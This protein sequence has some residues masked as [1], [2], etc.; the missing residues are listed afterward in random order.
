V[1]TFDGCIIKFVNRGYASNSFFMA[2]CPGAVTTTNNYTTRNGKTT[3]THRRTTITKEIEKLQSE[4]KD[5]SEKEAAL[6][7]LTTQ[8]RKALGIE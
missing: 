3:T 7:K 4:L 6:V 2:S 1:G 5:V 8:E